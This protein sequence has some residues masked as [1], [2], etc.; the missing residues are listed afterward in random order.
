MVT[1]ELITNKQTVINKSTVPNLPLL[2]TFI[3]APV[4][5]TYKEP[6]STNNSLIKIE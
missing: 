2:E 6:K 1:E 4:A 5:R 3:F